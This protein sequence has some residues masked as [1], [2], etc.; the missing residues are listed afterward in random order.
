M[1]NHFSGNWNA[2]NLCVVYAVVKLFG[3]A[4]RDCEEF[5]RRVIV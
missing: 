2:D 4:V 1:R 5:G 3:D